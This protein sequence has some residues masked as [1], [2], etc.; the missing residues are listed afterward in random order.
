MWAITLGATFGV[1]H[2]QTV[3]RAI[4][5]PAADQVLIR[6]RAASLNYRD[7][8]VINGQYHQVFPQGLV[9]LSD[10]STKLR[11]HARPVLE[12]KLA[13]IGQRFVFAA[14]RQLS[15]SFLDRLQSEATGQTPD[16]P[17]PGW[18]RRSM[19]WIQSL[20]SMFKPRRF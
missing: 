10:G 6:V 4:P 17:H 7:W 2:L 13:Q 18:L 15:E 14:A 3:E 5:E 12:G 11:W 9:P 19:R 16:R 1:E 20:F 8:E